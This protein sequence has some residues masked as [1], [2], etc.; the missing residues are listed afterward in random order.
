MKNPTDEEFRMM[1]WIDGELTDDDVAD[2]LKAD[3]SL[4]NQKQSSLEVGALLKSALPKDQEVPYGD[5]F[6]HRIL[7]RIEN[8][9]SENEAT[10]HETSEAGLFSFSKFLASLFTTQT[11]VLGGAAAMGVAML[12]TGLLLVASQSG[13]H[14][15]VTST[16]VPDDQTFQASSRFD[17]SA[18]AAVFEIDGMLTEGQTVAGYFPGNAEVDPLS[19]TTTIYSP[20]GQPMLMLTTDANGTPT[21]HDLVLT[22]G[23]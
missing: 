20:E 13:S 15:Q 11:M 18:N 7:N 14:T 22:T 3:P 8:L 23:L 9:Q 6:N 21:I 17:S 19:G 16:Y 4:I 12:C 2:L 5:F 10:H 1:R